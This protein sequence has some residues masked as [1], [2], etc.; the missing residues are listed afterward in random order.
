MTEQWFFDILDIIINHENNMNRPETSLEEKNKNEKATG[1]LQL[2]W[3]ENPHFFKL[4]YDG[5]TIA[6]NV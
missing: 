2:K 5:R 4:I 3:S 1:Q 6:Y